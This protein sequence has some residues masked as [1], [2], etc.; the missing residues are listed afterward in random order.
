MREFEVRPQNSNQI[1][2]DP[3]F[4]QIICWAKRGAKC[5]AKRGVKCYWICIFMQYLKSSHHLACLTIPFAMIFLFSNFDLPY[6]TAH[7]IINYVHI[8]KSK[9]FET[10]LWMRVIDVQRHQNTTR[11]TFIKKVDK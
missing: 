8:Q 2:F 1:T 4:G 11:V 6:N 3:P 10:F 9:F 5:W 7:Y